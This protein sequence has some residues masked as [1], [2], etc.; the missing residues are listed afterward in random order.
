MQI[1]EYKLLA[2]VRE[3]ERLRREVD[4]LKFR[5]NAAGAETDGASGEDGAGTEESQS[6]LVLQPPPKEPDGVS[7]DINVVDD[8]CGGVELKGFAGDNEVAATEISIPVGTE[9]S[10]HHTA[11]EFVVRTS[12]GE[13]AYRKVCAPGGGGSGTSGETGYHNFPTGL[14]LVNTGTSASPAWVLRLSYQQGRFQDGL[15]ADMANAAVQTV[16]VPVTL[17]SAITSGS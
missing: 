11:D 15:L 5:A 2:I 1:D 4:E 13:L 14:A 16:D 8:E 17:H 10:A 3:V 12:G 6:A 7:L 9:S